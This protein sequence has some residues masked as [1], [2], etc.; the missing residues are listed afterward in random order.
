MTLKICQEA[1]TEE[2]S[3]CDSYLPE[4]AVKRHVGLRW[5]TDCM[6]AIAKLSIQSKSEM[7]K[8][9]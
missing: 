2:Q 5:V 8:L 3:G 9:P 7:T 1:T 6:T 4:S